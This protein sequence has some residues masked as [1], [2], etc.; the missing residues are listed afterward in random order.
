[1]PPLDPDAR[2]AKSIREQLEKHRDNAACYD[3]HRKI[4][5]LGLAFENFD[6]IGRWRDTDGKFPVDAVGQLPG[7]APINGAT[8]LKDLILKRKNQFVRSFSGKLLTYAIGRG[9]KPFDRPVLNEI[10]GKSEKEGYKFSSVVFAI[11]ESDAFLKRR[12][13]RTD[14]K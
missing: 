5:P 6:A 7:E 8:G 4:D 3:C 14:E 11:V 13:K 1:V 9:L 10:V 2:G 12:D